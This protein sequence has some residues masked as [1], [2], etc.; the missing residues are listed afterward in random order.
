[1]CLREK[2]EEEDWLAAAAMKM[3]HQQER[4]EAKQELERLKRR[5]ERLAR[6]RARRAQLRIQEVE[7]NRDE[8]EELFKEVN[9]IKKAVERG[10]SQ[11]IM[12]F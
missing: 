5:E 10:V 3:D 11:V 9:W 4:L 1:L 6:I 7:K 2:D 8:F 12:T